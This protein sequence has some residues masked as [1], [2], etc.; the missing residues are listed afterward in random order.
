MILL[1]FGKDRPTR[2][3]VILHS[4]GVSALEACRGGQ[5]GKSFKQFSLL[6]ALTTSMVSTFVCELV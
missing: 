3:Q 2:D 1:E 6:Y 4:P 5:Q